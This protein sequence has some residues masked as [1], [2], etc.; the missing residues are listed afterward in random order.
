MVKRIV[1]L[2]LLLLFYS[3]TVY[4]QYEHEFFTGDQFGVKWD[5]SI[6]ANGYYWYI[7]RDDGFIIAQGNTI[8]LQVSISIQGAGIYVFY[9]RAWNFTEDGE[10][11]QYSGWATSLTHGLVNGIVQP[12]QIKVNLKPV[13]PLIF[14]G[15]DH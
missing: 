6:L 9:C 4:A 10:T 11:I 15:G 13:G 2:I 12:W 5:E 3:S 1:F 7:E 8:E 14:G